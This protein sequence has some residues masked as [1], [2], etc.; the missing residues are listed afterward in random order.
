MTRDIGCVSLAIVNVDKIASPIAIASD[1]F[2]EIPCLW[3]FMLS[4]SWQI[5]IY[6]GKLFSIHWSTL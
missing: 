3:L 6:L 4:I 5:V 2:A 1:R